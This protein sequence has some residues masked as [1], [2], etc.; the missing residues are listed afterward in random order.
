VDSQNLNTN[1]P[2]VSQ[3]EPLPAPTLEG[4]LAEVTAERDRLAAEKAELQDRLLRTRAEYDN[5]RR[6][7][8]RERS[9]FLQFAGMELVRDVLPVLDDFERALKT[10]GATPEYA[11]GVDLIY[12]RLYETLKKMG[13]EPVSSEG[14]KFDPNLHEAVQRV[15][16]TEAEDQTI[17]SEFQWGYNFK[18]R[19]LRPAMVKVAVKP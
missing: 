1:P 9:D 18:G 7:A 3:E 19:L 12:Q 10:E 2:E 5:A 11:R 15:E 8:E 13:L 6:R 16:T 17:L 4:Q 14:R